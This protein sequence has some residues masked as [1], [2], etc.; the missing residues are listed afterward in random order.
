MKKLLPLLFCAVTGTTFMVTALPAAHASVA[1]ARTTR[2]AA[3]LT[4]TDGTPDLLIGI[5][6]TMWQAQ[7]A[8][9]EA[10]LQ[11]GGPGQGNV[12]TYVVRSVSE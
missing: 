5:Y 4:Y 1:D 11:A 9:K 2:Y 10:L 7:A 12:G 6:D 8:G 3:Y